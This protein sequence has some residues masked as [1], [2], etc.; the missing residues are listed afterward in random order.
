MF[1]AVFRITALVKSDGQGQRVFRV[2][3]RE[4]PAN[5]AEFLSLPVV[6]LSS[7]CKEKIFLLHPS[8]PFCKKAPTRSTPQAAL[9]MCGGILEQPRTGTLFP[10]PQCKE[11]GSIAKTS[12][13]YCKPLFDPMQSPICSTANL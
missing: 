7:F 13:L 5:D 6:Y 10:L 9:K 1:E 3:E 4:A 8:L 11:H 2:T 12:S